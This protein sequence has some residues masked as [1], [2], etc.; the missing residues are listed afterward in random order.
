MGGDGVLT[1]PMQAKSM[2]LRWPSF[3]VVSDIGWFVIWQGFLRPLCKRYV[4]R[5]RYSLGCNLDDLRVKPFWPRVTVIDPPLRTRFE[6]PDEP[7]PH[8]YGE[9][10]QG[11][12]PVLCLFDPATDEWHP[13]LEVADTIVPWTIGWLACYEG[14]LA[15]GEWTGGGRHPRR[16]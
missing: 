11:E 7:I 6:Y 5:V 9:L 8:Q 2:A 14:W 1:I 10:I 13:R 4:V 16:I 12:G 15:T 3:S